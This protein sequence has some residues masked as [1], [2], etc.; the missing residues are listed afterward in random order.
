MLDNGRYILTYFLWIE[1][2]FLI[3]QRALL[4]SN[5]KV[6]YIFVQISSL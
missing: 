6:H 1:S 4:V 3:S 5:E 2:T